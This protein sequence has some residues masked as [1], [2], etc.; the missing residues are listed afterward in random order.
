MSPN[1]WTHRRQRPGGASRQRQPVARRVLAWFVSCRRS[2][3]ETTVGHRGCQAVL[4]V[5]EHDGRSSLDG[6]WV[7]VRLLCCRG[8]STLEYAGRFA[9][10]EV[11]MRA[12]SVVGVACASA[13]LAGCS[14]P[15]AKPSD[16]AKGE[17]SLPAMA[18]FVHTL[19]Y[20]QLSGRWS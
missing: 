19:S 15:R 10:T 4:Y 1:R 14:G 20:I 11:S 9:N 3:S 13:A 7:V 6:V 5:S 18:P 2:S 17:V 8:V 12:L 16:S